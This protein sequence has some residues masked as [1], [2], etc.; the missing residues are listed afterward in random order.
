MERKIKTDLGEITITQDISELPSLYD[1]LKKYMA[2][3]GYD[4]KHND[5]CSVERV[6]TPEGTEIYFKFVHVT[7]P[8][9]ETE[10]YYKLYFK[11]PIP[12]R[13]FIFS[14]RTT[15]QIGPD[16]FETYPVVFKATEKTT[17]AEVKEWYLS[18][19]SGERKKVDGKWIQD[20]SGIKIVGVNLTE[21]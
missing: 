10:P 19:M 13:E 3:K 20:K 21:V 16:E 7:V 11:H 8:T 4:I 5:I 12:V 17:L 18:H 1:V 15:T 9:M 6:G 2:D 14:F